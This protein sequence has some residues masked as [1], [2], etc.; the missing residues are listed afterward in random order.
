MGMNISKGQKAD[1]TKT[2][3]GLRSVFVGMGWQADAKIDLDT[4]AFLLGAG[5]KVAGDADFVFYGNARHAS[6]AVEHIAAPSGGDMQQVR[7]DLAA[8]PAAVEKIA[9][10]ATI[11]D[12]DARRQNFSQVAGAYIRIMDAA[13]GAE[14]LRY[15]LGQGFSVETAIVVGELYRYKGE[16]K[17]S[18]VGAGFSGGLEALCRNFGVEVGEGQ[19]DAP[20]APPAPP[21]APPRPA[22]PP[23]SPAPA[24]PPA[25]RSPLNLGRPGA[26]TAPAPHQPLNL[27]RPGAAPAP[28]VQPVAPP[29]SP[30]APPAQPPTAPKKVEL[31]KGQKVSL[32]KGGGGL[33]EIAINLNWHQQPQ[34]K[35]QGL[36]ASIFGGGGGAG[37]IDL[38]LGCLYE[39][40]DGKIGCVQ[41]LGNDFGSLSRR[42]W[43]ALDGDDRTGSNAAGETLRVNG[44]MA[45]KIKRILVYT[46]IYEGV[47]NWQ[48]ADGVVTV[49]CPGSPDII[50]RMDEY[51]SSMR[52]CAIAMLEN[53]NDT[54]SVEKLVQFFGGHK[55]MDAAYHWGLRWE[56]G[57][58][59]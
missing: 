31:K 54:F 37:G 16:W 26:E 12:A 8:V 10:T 25:Q 53:I 15:D 36:L 34:T 5:G 21:T 3:A 22:A 41:A 33:G 45:S 30:A 14:L 18:A 28:P 19:G 13:S 1:L 51:G 11:Y 40:Q 23:I 57:S 27:G 38:D 32:V 35:K 49:K 17:F 44:K 39:L 47:A 56:A 58:K 50:V 29:V 48:Q 24:A 6:G 42:P 7:V 9:V 2:N 52:M 4:A 20:A 43:I 59:D 55:M 46:F